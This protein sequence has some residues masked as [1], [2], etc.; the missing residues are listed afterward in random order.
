MYHH[1]LLKQIMNIVDS[2][3]DFVNEKLLILS[4]GYVGAVS[5]SAC[6]CDGVV[7]SLLGGMIIFK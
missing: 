4:E 3:L 1:H 2:Y 5:A 6:K 7:R